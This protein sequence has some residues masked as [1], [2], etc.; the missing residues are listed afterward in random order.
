MTRAFVSVIVRV[1][2]HFHGVVMFLVS[3]A[4]RPA[5]EPVGFISCDPP[6]WISPAIY[7]ISDSFR[8][9]GQNRDAFQA[10]ENMSLRSATQLKDANRL[11]R[12]T[13]SL[14]IFALQTRSSQST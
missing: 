6:A 4:C 5:N 7:H 2:V 13:R 14:A 8:R 12:R 11:R 9:R 1:W 10:T 3:A